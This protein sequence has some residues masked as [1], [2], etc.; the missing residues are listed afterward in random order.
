MPVTTTVE[1]PGGVVG[2]VIIVKVLLPDPPEIVE[3]GLKTGDA[4]DGSP[5]V[6]VSETAPVNPFDGV[7]DRAYPAD[8]AP[9]LTV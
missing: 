5:E 8:V 1:A 3:E 4:L 9:W 6:T 7:T 2:P